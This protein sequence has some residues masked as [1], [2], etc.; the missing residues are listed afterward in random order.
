MLKSPASLP[1]LDLMLQHLKTEELHMVITE[2]EK[3]PKTY[4]YVTLQNSTVLTKQK[5]V[6]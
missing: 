2:G 1:V 4:L 5:R 6:L 3:K